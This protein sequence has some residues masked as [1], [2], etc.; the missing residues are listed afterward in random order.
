MARY[1]GWLKIET[2]RGRGLKPPKFCGG[3]WEE[4]LQGLQCNSSLCVPQKGCKHISAQCV[5]NKGSKGHTHV[6]LE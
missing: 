2:E 6:E 5:S 1:L 4:R 3:G